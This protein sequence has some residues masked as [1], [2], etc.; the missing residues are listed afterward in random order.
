MITQTFLLQFSSIGIA[1]GVILIM[2]LFFFLGES[3]RKIFITRN[4]NFNAKNFGAAEGALLG[5]LALLLSFTFNMSSSRHDTR[6]K[7]IVAEA[8]NIGTAVLRADLYPDS[9]RKAFRHDFKA[10]VESRIEFF[11]AGIDTAKIYRS[12]ATSNAIQQSLWN[13]AATLGQYAYNFHRT[14][15]MVPALNDMIDIVTTR[16]AA[17]ID[18]V[19]ELII[20]V[21]FLLCFT[22]AFMLGYD[23]GKKADWVI[24]VGFVLM[25]SMTIYLIIDLDRPRRGIITM[26][27]MNKQIVNLRAMFG[28]DE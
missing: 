5:L 1:L 14:S 12:L 3:L 16:N 18:K 15:Q 22:S 25:I 23:A 19:P 8:N 4:K 28:P 26:T 11:Q 24:T 7:V 27:N 9:I 6:I 20:Y 10:Y 17:D 21:L 13:R 2:L